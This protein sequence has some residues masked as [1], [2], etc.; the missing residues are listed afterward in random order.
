[1]RG[2]FNLGLN[3]IEVIR[4]GSEKVNIISFRIIFWES[5][6]AGTRLYFKVDGW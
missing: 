5:F 6:F 3:C 1:M 4:C 2:D